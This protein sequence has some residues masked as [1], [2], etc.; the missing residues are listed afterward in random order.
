[1]ARL[2]SA[3]PMVYLSESRCPRGAMALLYAKYWLDRGYGQM[4]ARMKD[5]GSF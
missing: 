3:V 4:D 5:L 2:F 1:V